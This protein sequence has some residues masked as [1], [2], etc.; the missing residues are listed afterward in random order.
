[1]R[2]L[3]AAVL[4]ATLAGG[5]DEDVVERL[6]VR[7]EAANLAGT[8]C[9]DA[10]SRHLEP[11]EAAIHFQYHVSGEPVRGSERYTGRVTFSL[12]DVVIITPASITWPHMTELDREHVEALRRAI[13]HHEVG[14]VRVAEALRDE[15]NARP[16]IVAPDAFAFRA[17]AD[18]LGREG[19]DRFNH[20]ERAYDDLTDH[21]RK[22]HAAPGVLA[23]PDTAIVC[24]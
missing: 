20:D 18:A 24:R 11:G 13:Y 2:R 7:F 3:L 15:L 1:V 17:A 4:A 16:P 8:S 10:I 22:Q 21:G 19:F 12:G 6:H 5:S 9:R 14:H 23:G